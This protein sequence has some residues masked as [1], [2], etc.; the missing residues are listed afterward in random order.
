MTLDLLVIGGAHIDRRG[1]LD[2]ATRLGASNPGTWL[3]E[4]G[5]GAF[6]AARNLTRLGR[7]VRMVAPR[8]GDIHGERVAKAAEQ[9]G[10]EDCPV[11]FLDR[12]TP[13]YT[14]ILEN[15]GN[16]I[17]AL[18]DMA[19][20]E[21]FT[22]R[23]LKSRLL[24]ESL[25]AANHVLCDANL[26]AET[27]AQLAADANR[28]GKPVAAI[29]ISPAKV[30]RLKAALP[31]LDHVFM[32]AAEAL[33]LSGTQAETPADWPALLRQAGL[34]AGTV[35]TG[36]GPTVAF[37]ETG[38]VLLVPPRLDTIADVTG[39]GDAF[40]AGF[41]SARIGG[42]PLAEAVRYGTACAAITL[43]SPHA[44]SQDLSTDRLKSGLALVP[45]PA[46]LS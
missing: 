9:A 35:T 15:D 28:L 45:T 46:I 18:A 20:Y 38:T 23:R 11:V 5:G 10:I 6:N 25:T 3:E 19:L 7:T 30:V 42:E 32:N 16:L 8:G 34:R 21:L 27:I 29:A 22:P 39:A 44:V 13:S 31:L 37:D 4:A 36:A 43:T 33:V 17:V 2:G 14:A 26:P 41:L 1:R 12:A 40:A 24:R